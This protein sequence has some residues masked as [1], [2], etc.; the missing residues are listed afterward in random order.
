MIRRFRQ[1]TN[2]LYRGSAPNPKDVL[3]LKEKL[4]INKIVSLDQATGDK[5]DR[6]CKLLNIEHIKDYING[7][8]KTL[9]H[10]LS[11]NLKHLLI[12]GGPTFFHCHEGKDRTG[13]ICA[14]FKCKYMGM[15]PDKAIEEAKSLGFGI[16]VDPKIVHLYERI[17]R[18]CKPSMDKD[19]N[20]A[21]IVGNE[22]EYVGDNR[23]SFLDEANRGSFAPYLN[24]TRQNPI[25]AVY[26]FVDDQSPT[27]QNYQQTWEE[28]K[29]RLQQGDAIKQ[30]TDDT[31]ENVPQ[32]GIFDNDAGVRGFGPTEPVGGFIYD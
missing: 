3:L 8:R 2:G 24:H 11:Q 12:D 14:L 19:L 23:D 17:I 6:T 9:Y 31:S 18:S 5:I 27:R 21:D 10:V 16:G 7:D 29:D 1:V 32:V 13:L 15:N 20:H 26:N 28:P 25:D 22:R 30:H 4:G